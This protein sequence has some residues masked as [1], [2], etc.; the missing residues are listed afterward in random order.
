MQC[1]GNDFEF[2]DWDEM[3]DEE[4]CADYDEE[5]ETDSD[6]GMGL[7]SPDDSP[8]VSPSTR[9]GEKLS[10]PQMFPR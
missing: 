8:T 7:I 5:A 3:D 2:D 10:Q 1:D 9:F 4:R 6:M